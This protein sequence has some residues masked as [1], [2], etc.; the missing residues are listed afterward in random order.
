[1]SHTA[2]LRESS[3][4]QQPGPKTLCPCRG[5]PPS[6]GPGDETQIFVSLTNPTALRC[7]LLLY[8]ST[9]ES[10][11]GTLLSSFPGIG[12]EAATA[13]RRGEAA[14]K[15][16]RAQAPRSKMNMCGLLSL[17]FYRPYFDVDTSQVKGR[18]LQ[19]AWPMRQTSPFLD[20]M[21]T[22]GGDDN[23]APDLYGPVWVSGLFP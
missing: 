6:S 3:N 12:G 8:L 21:E 15:N 19:A 16:S 4:T 22:E 11:R 5:L 7:Q 2:L 23:G 1:M 20:Q 14:D 17:Q 9:A 10:E 13:G 18:L